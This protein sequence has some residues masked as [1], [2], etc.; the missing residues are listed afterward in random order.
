[1][2]GD[3]LRG[4]ADSQSVDAAKS[5]LQ[6]SRLMRDSKPLI[7]Q[8]LRLSCPQWSKPSTEGLARIAVFTVRHSVSLDFTS[9]RQRQV[10]ERHTAG[11][12]WP[13]LRNGTPHRTLAS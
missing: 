1:M 13:V 9:P 7:P 5:S 6:K 8:P 3:T 2:A 10:N 11:A 4:A 12:S